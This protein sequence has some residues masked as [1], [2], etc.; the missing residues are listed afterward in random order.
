MKPNVDRKYQKN[1]TI[2]AYPHAL[3]TVYEHI[4]SKLKNMTPRR[5]DKRKTFLWGGKGG[6]TFFLWASTKD[7]LSALQNNCT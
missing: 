3:I 1:T 5:D 7:G 4:K 2:I 6:K